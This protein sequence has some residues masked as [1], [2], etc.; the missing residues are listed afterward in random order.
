VTDHVSAERVLLIAALAETD[1]EKLQARSHAT[2]C[3]DCERLIRDGERMVAL[4]DRSQPPVLV[5]TELA[6]RVRRAV[7][8]SAPA[9]EGAHKR[10]QPLTWLAGAALSALLI[11]LDGRPGGSLA[12][13]GGVHCVLLENGYALASCAGAA[14]WARTRRQQI[15][16]WTG[17][18]VGMA[19]ALL[20]QFLLRTQCEAAH[21]A[22][23]V[24][25]FHL[26]G[27][28]LGTALGA[29][30]VPLLTRVR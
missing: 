11:W 20:G 12:G 21:V 27:V 14:I 24:L 8:A 13:S 18:V 1:P 25:V 23:H 19:G 28:A 5:S 16:P 6:D 10:W 3:T 15:D 29:V 30:S 17:S 9:T 26:L 7:F 4:L 22:L 2:A